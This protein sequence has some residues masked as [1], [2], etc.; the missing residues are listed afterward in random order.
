MPEIGQAISHYRII[1]KL[2]QGGMGEVFLADDTSLHR[3]V[4]LKFL[5]P[6]MQR[7]VN[8]R[9]RFIREA[10]SV[11]ALDHPFICHINEV[12]EFDGQDIIVMEYVEGQSLKDKL[13]MGPLPLKDTLQI[14]IEVA[15][16]LEAAHG[17]GII[18]RDIKPA[19][20]MLTQTGHAKVMDFGLAK[21][22]VPSGGMESTKETITALTSDGTTVGTL[23]YMSPE[24]LRSQAVDSRSDI[25]AVGV[26]LYEM[27]TGARPFQGRTPFE[28][29]SAILSQTP[30]PLTTGRTGPLPPGLITIIERCLEKEPDR[31]YQHCAEVRAALEAVQSSGDVPA[32]V[33]KRHGLSRRA[34]LALAAVLAVA[35]VTIIA[36]LTGLNL[37]GVR[38]RLIGTL[39]APR[40]RSLS[41]L[42][43]ANLSGDSAQEDFADGMTEELITVLSKIKGLRVTA[44]TS[45]MKFKGTNQTPQEIAS[46]L[47]VEAVL[48]GSVM[49]E[50]SRVRVTAQLYEAATGQQLWADRYER[51]FASVLALQSELA[52]AVAG[53][54][55]V[56]LT[57]EEES[58]LASVR[59]VDS[60]AYE[61]YLRGMSHLNKGTLSE[62]KT[63]LTYFQE[64]VD[65][66]PADPLANAGLA[67]GYCE[68]AH[69][70]E[71][72]ED[73]LVKAKAAAETALKLD[74]TLAEVFAARAMVEGYKEWNWDAAF[75]DFDR[76]LDINPSLAEAY[77]HRA[78]LHV[79]FGHM[80]QAEQDQKRAWELNP[81]APE[82]RSHLGLLYGYEG[83][84][85]EATAE[86][87]KSIEMAPKYPL[88]YA[89]LA[90]IYQLRGM[91]NDAIAASQKAAELSHTYRWHVG[92]IYAAAGRREEAR[93][94]LAE[95]NQQKPT[96]F[97]VHW[98]FQICIAL[99][100][101]DEAFRWLAY[102]PH[103]AWVPWITVNPAFATLR[104]DS[105][106]PDLLR[107]MNLPPLPASG[108]R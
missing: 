58:R 104:K 36:V 73:S 25:W 96:P 47:N 71:A 45:A 95:L 78:W 30:P 100:E 60:A 12:A 52:R 29:S 102:E 88:G 40:F 46:A 15:E 79:L 98:R 93:K 63:G 69:S 106:F 92:A 11:A 49:R 19:N 94:L 55:K 9:K 27:A 41:V 6:E 23:A 18:H 10:R 64:A 51:E 89:F 13:V 75:R 57:P 103:H 14:T 77:F 24:Q 70:A 35:S 7:D 42:P 48:T 44:R 53:A 61:A 101:M 74:S 87:L 1:E 65:K 81:F 54:I 97:D 107:R 108:S 91:Y 5:P 68:I 4:A 82:V 16:A 85:E 50:A 26:T 86:A 99:G 3:K 32:W 56:R 34:W 28:L 38:N 67:L 59:Q 43:M 84:Y 80:E 8:A 31:R 37:E 83:R 2:G 62:A 20:I 90:N 76:A 66:D 22:L 72:Q 39:E 105:R 33:G 21:Q 17:K